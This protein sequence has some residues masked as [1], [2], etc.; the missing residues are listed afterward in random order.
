[1]LARHAAPSCD[2]VFDGGDER[3]RH[4][5]LERPGTTPGQRAREARLSA[6]QSRPASLESHNHTPRACPTALPSRAWRPGPPCSPPPHTRRHVSRGLPQPPAR[7]EAMSPVIA[8]VSVACRQRPREPR[9]RRLACGAAHRDRSRGCHPCCLS[10]FGKE[11]LDVL[12]RLIQVLEERCVGGIGVDAE[13]R[14]RAA[15]P[16]CP[17]PRSSRCARR[18]CRARARLRAARRGRGRCLAIAGSPVDTA[19]SS[20]RMEGSTPMFRATSAS[21]RSR[22]PYPPPFA[23]GAT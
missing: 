15:G 18:R 7:P 8:P 17:W 22:T 16:R 10:R 4:T 5:P 9:I 14:R 23:N 12:R 3:A 2:D 6:G 11:L 21:V 13:V 19:L 20:R 1:M